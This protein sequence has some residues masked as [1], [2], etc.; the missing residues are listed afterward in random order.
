M[1][2]TYLTFLLSRRKFL[3]IRCAKHRLERDPLF[4]PLTADDDSSWDNH[5]KANRANVSLQTAPKIAVRTCVSVHALVPL[6]LSLSLSV[7]FS[8]SPCTRC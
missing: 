6:S 1:S 8:P 2:G 4:F 5:S 7:S 3:K